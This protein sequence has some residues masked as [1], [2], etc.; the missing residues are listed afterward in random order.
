MSGPPSLPAPT[1]AELEQQL[2]EALDAELAGPQGLA[3]QELHRRVYEDVDFW[4][5]Q[6]KWLMKHGDSRRDQV[7]ATVLK[8]VWDKIAP[9]LKSVGRAGSGGGRVHTM[10][11]LGWKDKHGDPQQAQVGVAIDDGSEA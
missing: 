2:D 7:K 9:D 4:Y 11:K 1:R 8:M 3:R 5:E 6:A 10:V